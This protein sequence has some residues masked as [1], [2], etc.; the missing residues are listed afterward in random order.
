MSVP[1]SPGFPVTITD[2]RGVAVRVDK[3]PARI[4]STAPVVT[5]ILF[6]VGAGDR[7]VAVTNQCNYPPEVTKLPRVGGFF[8]PSAEKV[9]A[10]TPDL[11]IGSRGNP[12]EFL[13]AVHASGCPVFTV[14]PRTLDDIYSAVRQIA[15]LAGMPDGGEGTVT[16]MQ[17]RLAAVAGKLRDIAEDRRPTAFIFLQVDPI[18]TAGADTFQDGVIRAAGARNTA[19]K[20]ESFTAFPSESLIAADPD[21]L[22]LSTMEG[23]PEAMVREVASNP[24]YQRLFAV[25]KGHLIV[26][27]ADV[28]MRPGPRVVEAVETMAKCFYPDRFGA[29]PSPSSSTTSSR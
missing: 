22:I 13:S 10:A 1:S 14:D 8:S 27:D 20:L 11:V 21:Y 5:E 29:A 19:G 24:V 12:P 6:A 25:K 28:I 2:A 16:G 17:G 9:L 26:L 18:W 23:D 15:R 4:V 7:V 3:R